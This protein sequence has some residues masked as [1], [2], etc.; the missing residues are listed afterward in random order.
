MLRLAPIFKGNKCKYIEKNSYSKPFANLAQVRDLSSTSSGANE[1]GG[2]SNLPSGED[3]I[4]NVM[5]CKTKD[6]ANV[7]ANNRVIRSP[8]Q[9]STSN[10][11]ASTSGCAA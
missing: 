7:K 8:P 6:R 5:D 2:A 10:L 11:A 9:R 3:S 4:A 1:M